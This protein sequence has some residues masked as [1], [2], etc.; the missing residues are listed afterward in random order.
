[1]IGRPVVLQSVLN[2]LMHLRVFHLVGP[3]ACAAPLAR[4]ALGLFRAVAALARIAFQFTADRTAVAAQQFRN[5]RIRLS[6]LLQT[7]Y[8]LSL[9]GRKMT[10]HRWASVRTS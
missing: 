10:S 5:P 4:Q 8:D 9:C 2:V 3:A 1:L 6:I 7:V